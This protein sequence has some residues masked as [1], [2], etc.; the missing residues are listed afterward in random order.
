MSPSSPTLRRQRT[1]GPRTLGSGTLLTWETSYEENRAALWSH[2][3]RVEERRELSSQQTRQLESGRK[4]L[5]QLDLEEDVVLRG[6]RSRY[7]FD[8]DDD[9]DASPRPRPPSP[10]VTFGF[11]DDTP[12]SDLEDASRCLD[13][14]S[15]SMRDSM[16]VTSRE[17]SR[18]SGHAN[19]A[20]A[21][22]TSVRDDRPFDA[23]VPPRPPSPDVIVVS[24]SE[25]R[26]TTNGDVILQSEWF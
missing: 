3:S 23:S 16:T 1:I 17:S 19:A 8:D 21:D 4:L 13:S 26:E 5:A 24:E 18:H 22:A 10:D 15:E 12:V 6:T 9:D 2:T 25:I 11:E 7:G 20:A 14:D